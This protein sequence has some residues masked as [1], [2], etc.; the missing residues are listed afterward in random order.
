[1]TS[2]PK[3]RNPSCRLCKGEQSRFHGQRYPAIVR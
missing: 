1:V 2:F 3:L